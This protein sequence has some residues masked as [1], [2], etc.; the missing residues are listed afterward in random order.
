[1]NRAALAV[2]LALALAAI[3]PVAGTARAASIPTR[4]WPTAAAAGDWPTF[5]HDP[6]RSAADLAETVLS[7]ATAPNLA[8]RWAARIGSPI[9]S[10]PAVVGGVLY[11]GAADGYEYALNAATGAQLWRTFLGVTNIP[12]CLP[13]MGVTSSAAVQDGVVYVG[14][15]DA[16]WYALDAGSGSVLWRVFTGDNSEVGGHYNWSSPLLYNGY[17]YIGVASLGDCPLVQGQLLQVSLNT[18]TVV[19]T[20]DVVP[21]GQV[22]AGIWTS[23]TVDPATGTVFVATGTQQFFLQSRAQSLVALDAATLSP[24]SWWQIPISDAVVDSDW[25]DTPVLFTDAAG[26]QRV[27][28]INKDGLVYAFDRNNVSAGPVWQRQVAIG[29]ACPICGDG[30]VSSGA[31][32]GTRLY[33]GGGNSSIAGTGA[34]GTVRALDPRTGAPIGEH[35][36]PGAVVGSLAYAG[37]L[38]VDGAGQ[39]LEV[40]DA[41]TGTRLFSYATGGPIYAA[42]S[43]SNGTIFAGSTDGL[44]YAFA[45]VAAVAPPPDPACPGGWTCQDVG[46]PSPAGGEAATG[47]RWTV[48]AGGSGIAGTADQFRLI[49]QSPV[50]DGRVIAQLAASPGQPQG[51]QAGVMVRQSN[52]PASPYYAVLAGPAGLA[53]QYRRGPGSPSTVL[54]NGP[55]PRPSA[56]LE[57]VR[58]GDLLQAATSPDG[59]AFTLVP[60]T[61]LVLPM[62]AA[63]LEGVATSSHVAGTATTATYAGVTLAGPGSTPAPAP[64]ATPCPGGWSCGDVGNPGMVGDQSLSGA[65]WTVRGAGT[66]IAGYADQ[67]HYVWQSLASDGTIAARVTSLPTTG[68]AARAGVMMRQSASDSRSAFYGA[69]AVPGGGLVVAAR[70]GQGQRV[71][72]LVT[73]SIALPASIEIARSGSTYCT[74]TSVGGGG[75]TYLP[76]SCLALGAPGAVLAG[77]AV[78]SGV[79][80]MPATGAIDTVSIGLS[81]PPVPTVCP[82]GWSCADIGFPK[83]Q[84]S[85]SLS[86]G[87]WTILGSGADIWFN[88]DQFRFVWQPLAADGVISARITA[89]S[90]TD[91]WAKTGMMLRQSTDPGS[92]FYA[93]YVTPANGMT[94]QFRASQG[95][96]VSAVAGLAGSVPTYL[97]VARYGN[98]FCAYTSGDG[99]T[100]TFVA[101][102]CETIGMTG[103]VLA[104]MAVTAHNDNALGTVTIDSVGLATTAPTPPTACRSS[105]WTCADIGN[106]TPTGSQTATGSA[107][108]VLAGGTDIWNGS[109]QFHLISQPLA[110]DGAV[111][112]RVA[113]QTGSDPWAKA[114]VMLRQSSDPASPYYAAFVTPANG[115]VVQFRAVAGASA[116]QAVQLAGAAPAFLEVARSGTTY[117]AYTS[118]DGVTWRY[119]HGSCQVINIG[120]QVLGGLAAT[121]HNTAT[122]STVTFDT[123][124]VG[125][126]APPP[127]VLCPAG[128]TCTDVGGATPSGDQVLSNGT[129]TIDGGGGDIWGTSDQFHL[130]SQ[131]LSGNGAVSARVVAQG[132]SDPWAKAGVML[133]QSTDAGSPY[134]AAYVTPGHGVVVQYR[135]GPGA[136]AVTLATQAG[137]PPAYLRVSVSANAF[138]AFTSADGV[139]W[140]PIAGSSVTFAVTSPLLAGLAV[141]S[142]NA[143]TQSQVTFDTANAGALAVTPSGDRP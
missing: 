122:T 103:T 80:G 143:S 116:A 118:A 16:Y 39:T 101:G 121:S 91:P 72:Q 140:T 109:D 53:V 13:Q 98:V 94:V 81:A 139:T 12:A 15:G 73:A 2:T 82:S 62:P 25:G 106:P 37:G 32:D 78:T 59:A 61:D 113:S 55:G 89:Q 47:G 125:A 95:G 119:I 90:N 120:G 26:D 135:G 105:V 87:A 69:F 31:F 4:Q 142:H 45:P 18:H 46:G 108:T 79:S 114:G 1:M 83:N 115:V 9:D 126:P 77:M 75:W 133:R 141:T 96:S 134:Y 24:K 76:G 11:V 41:G 65:T 84:G 70:A 107:W 10:S 19:R 130:V 14:G 67:F 57:I 38:I 97:E 100:W 124:S 129:W 27:A 137:Q 102:S 132:N 63:A 111:S 34:V 66:G 30:S 35:G 7:P 131:P 85:Q 68:A 99:V 64:T 42:P 23:P 6:Q 71:R 50:G 21:N 44:V 5:L 49:A 43:V 40:L 112:A 88:F 36:A 48:S 123:V 56:F 20:F 86:G 17:A 104:G 74:Y 33:L 60:G 128:W 110:G 22:G 54:A 127:P 29:G 117:C 92:P 8:V 28:A 52:D 93:L 58:T 136:S 138:T 51:A 3:W